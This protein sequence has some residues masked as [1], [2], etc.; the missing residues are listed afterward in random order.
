MAVLSNTLLFAQ[1]L[2]A[3]SLTV[4]G[5]FNDRRART[6]TIF[7]GA[8][9]TVIAGL[10][11]YF[12]SRNQPNRARQFRNDLGVIVDQLDDAEANFRNPNWQGNEFTTMEQIRNAYNQARA[13]AQANYPDLWVKGTTPYNPNYT[14]RTET[15]P[16]TGITGPLSHPSRA[17]TWS[18]L[19]TTVR[20]GTHPSATRPPPESTAHGALAAG[21]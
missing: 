20:H 5:A 3:A 6:A 16:T 18:P 1:I 2:I 12:K 8:T 15:D 19:R 14:P 9:N 7:L 11:T 17:Q 10:L 4:L 21:S 13:D